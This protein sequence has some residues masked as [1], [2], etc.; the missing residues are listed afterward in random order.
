MKKILEEVMF[1][2][3]G[4]HEDLYYPR[5]KI[6]SPRRVS[7]AFLDSVEFKKESRF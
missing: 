1:E 3:E 7:D 4:I 5:G 6:L 2:V